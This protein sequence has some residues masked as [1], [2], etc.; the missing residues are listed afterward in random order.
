MW[1]FSSKTYYWVSVFKYA[2][3]MNNSQK[4]TFLSFFVN[5]SPGSQIDYFPQLHSECAFEWSRSDAECL[6][7]GNCYL[8]FSSPSVSYLQNFLKFSLLEQKN[9]KDGIYCHRSLLDKAECLSATL[10]RFSFPPWES[11]RKELETMQ[12]T[13]SIQNWGQFRG[14]NHV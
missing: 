1:W 14:G 8:S 2:Y 4:S 12:G 7:R 11:N 13:E 6:P 5:L 10:N 3:Y 9:N